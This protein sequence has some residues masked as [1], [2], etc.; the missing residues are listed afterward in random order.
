MPLIIG[1]GKDKKAKKIF[2]VFIFYQKAKK[3]SAQTEHQ[4]QNFFLKYSCL[5][6]KRMCKKGLCRAAKIRSQMC[7]FVPSR[8]SIYDKRLALLQAVCNVNIFLKTVHLLRST[9]IARQFDICKL[10]GL[11]FFQKPFYAHISYIYVFESQF[12]KQ[13]RHIGRQY[14]ALKMLNQVF[15]N[16]RCAHRKRAF[17]YALCWLVVA[18]QEVFC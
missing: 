10:S 13:I 12:Q 3:H 15:P 9:N 2:F 16:L 1:A 17:A 5:I 18:L 4:A 7:L 14:G 6:N 11:Y 8:K